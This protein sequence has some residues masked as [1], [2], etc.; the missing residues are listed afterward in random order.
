MNKFTKL[1]KESN[2]ISEDKVKSIISDLKKTT[3][4]LELEKNKIKDI[5]DT[6]ESF[7]SDKN[8]NDQIDDS[9]VSLKEIESILNE[10][11]VKVGEVDSRME[12]YLKE[13]RKYLY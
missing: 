8:K 3:S 9:Y 5:I 11:V 10:C 6:L 4:S 13:G 7:R 2:D 1:V 12:N